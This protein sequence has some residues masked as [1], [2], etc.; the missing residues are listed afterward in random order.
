MKNIFLLLALCA[1][2]L[3]YAADTNQPVPTPAKTAKQ[4]YKQTVVL[5]CELH[6][7]A[8]CDKIMKNIA[9]EKGVKDLVCDLKNQTVTV[10]YD[11]RKTDLE[12]LLKAF[13]KIGKPAKVKE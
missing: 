7:Q 11:S 9:W 13:E 10:T 5:T 4:S 12:T 3:C 6:C 2:P 8:C 1:L